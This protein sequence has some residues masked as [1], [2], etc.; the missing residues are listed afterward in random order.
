MVTLAGDFYG[1]EKR[2]SD[3]GPC[4][5]GTAGVRGN[6]RWTRCQRQW[7]A[8]E[9]EVRARVR[10]TRRGHATGEWGRP[11]SGIG[12]E[13]RAHHGVGPCG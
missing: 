3:V 8:R 5:S 9:G 10:Q 13:Q 6:G 4:G 2:N 7:L 11:V 1:A 12:E